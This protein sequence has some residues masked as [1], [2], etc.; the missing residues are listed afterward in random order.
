MENDN[1]IRTLHENCPILTNPLSL[2]MASF[3]MIAPKESGGVSFSAHVFCCQAKFVHILHQQN[4]LLLLPGLYSN[5]YQPSPST[6]CGENDQ[7]HH[8]HVRFLLHST[9]NQLRSMDQEYPTHGDHRGFKRGCS[10][11]S[12]LSGS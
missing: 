8:P 1:D 2:S 4:C 9:F 5:P 12:L 10:T 7:H 11:I 6:V 3:P